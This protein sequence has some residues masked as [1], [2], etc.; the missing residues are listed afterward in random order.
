MF[1]LKMISL[2]LEI[3][4]WNDNEVTSTEISRTTLAAFGSHLNQNGS[5]HK[6]KVEE[7]RK[8]QYELSVGKE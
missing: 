7:E 1:K 4:A 2:I 3:W 8:S 5:A 6:E